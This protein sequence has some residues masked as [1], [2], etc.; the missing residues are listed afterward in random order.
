MLAGV[1]LALPTL[2]RREREAAEVGETVARYMVER[3]Q[4]ASKTQMEALSIARS[5]RRWAMIAGVAA[6]VGIPA[7]IIVA[8]F[9]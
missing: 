6:V 7:T 3:D 8:L 1:L 4:E 9:V 2:R 5:S